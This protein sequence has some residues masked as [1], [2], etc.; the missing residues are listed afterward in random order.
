LRIDINLIRLQ[1]S[2]QVTQTDNVIDS[3]GR[4]NTRRSV[5]QKSSDQLTHPA[6]IV[7]SRR[8]KA[9]STRHAAV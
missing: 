4:T 5:R 8:H 6:S 2:L 9:S 7:L 1:V 3:R